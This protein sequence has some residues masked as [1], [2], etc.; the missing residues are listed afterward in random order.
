[1]FDNEELV[2]KELSVYE[3]NKELVPDIKLRRHENSVDT[4]AFNW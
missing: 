1:M 4:V 3:R 2:K